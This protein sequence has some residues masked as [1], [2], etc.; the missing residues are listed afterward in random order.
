MAGCLSHHRWV[1]SLP[2]GFQ[3][4]PLMRALAGEV[5]PGLTGSL[6]DS[7]CMPRPQKLC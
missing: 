1:T 6:S 5:L 7:S 3:A 2:S 4:S